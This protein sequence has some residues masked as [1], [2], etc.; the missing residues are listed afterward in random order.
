MK[1]GFLKVAAATPHIKVA[2]CEYNG[3]QIRKLIEEA[4]G[5]SAKI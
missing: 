5:L 2:D 3:Q 1:D 4:D